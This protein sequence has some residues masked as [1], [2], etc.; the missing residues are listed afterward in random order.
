MARRKKSADH[1][2]KVQTH[3]RPGERTP[4]WAELWRRILLDVLAQKD[5]L[6][7]AP[8]GEHTNSR[9]GERPLWH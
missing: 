4:A 7:D 9:K 8:V 5:E 3:W 1:D 2:F 6:A